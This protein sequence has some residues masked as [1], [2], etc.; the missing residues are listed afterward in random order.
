MAEGTP[1][2]TLLIM[3]VNVRAYAPVYYDRSANDLQ[4][5]PLL[6][7]PHRIPITPTGLP[8][9]C[10]PLHSTC[11]HRLDARRKSLL[12]PCRFHK[13][14]MLRQYTSFLLDCL[15][16]VS[17]DC[18]VFTYEELGMWQR[19]LSVAATR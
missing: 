14:M 16:A 4:A 8:T 6:L 19:P 13:C 7:C 3:N 18:G 17:G 1:H 15:L 2:G 5:G 12:P 9:P 11:L 10:A